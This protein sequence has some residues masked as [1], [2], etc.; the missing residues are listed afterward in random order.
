M[1]VGVPFVTTLLEAPSELAIVEGPRTSIT[2]GALADQ[3]L[4]FAHHLR[5]RGL[6]P[7]D[8]VLLQVPNGIGFA[9]T[10]LGTLLAGGVPVLLQPGFGDAVYRS[11]I[12]LAAPRFTVEHALLPAVRWVPGLTELLRRLERDI[13]PAIRTPEPPLRVDLRTLGRL[14]VPPGGLAAFDPPRRDPRDD[15]VL[16]FTGG[17]S[18]MPKCVRVSL[19]SL[20]AFLLN[21]FSAIEGLARTS[22]LADTP[23]Q[24]LY[25]LRKGQ[26]VHIARGRKRKRAAHVMGLMQ[27]G[28]VD[29]YFGSPYVW[30]EMAELHGGTP[31]TMPASL[32]TVLLGSAPATPGFLRQLLDRLHPDTHVRIIYGMTEVGAI[33]VVEARAKLDYDGVGDLVGAPLAGVRVEVVDR[34]PETG[35]GEIVVHSEALFTGYLGREPLAP[36]EGLRTGDLALE[37][38]VD[39][40]RMLT[41]MGRK[42]DMIIRHSVNIYPLAFEA[43]IKADLVDRHGTHLLRECAMVG[44]WNE[45]REDEDVV[46]FLEP[47]PG[48]DLADHGV[49]TAV[50]AICGT[51]AKPDRLVFVDHIPVTGRQ[52]KVDKAALRADPRALAPQSP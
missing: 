24:V 27:D 25:G 19:G 17:T 40:Q 35:V 47:A 38:E 4:A 21:V 29:A 11:R 42:K 9:T 34:H 39:G 48:I 30:M 22:F 45:A 16:V 15:A 49:A 13:P 44:V 14:P 32:R 28:A 33:S 8:R 31:P 51:D 41:L 52:N 3:V 6:V 20:E 18:S 26:T 7:G 2:R 46:I 12:T 43:Q 37:V 36:G 5:T 10:A 50:D 1:N 23:P